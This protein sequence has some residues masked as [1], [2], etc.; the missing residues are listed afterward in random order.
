M[1]NS[2]S[3]SDLSPTAASRIE[4]SAFKR[5]YRAV[6]LV[7]ALMVMAVGVCVLF[8]W[9]TN[10]MQFVLLGIGGAVMVF[11][12]AFCFVLTAL[13]LIALAYDRFTIMRSLGAFLSVIAAIT[14]IQ[15][16]VGQDLG[17]DYLLF[18]SHYSVEPYTGLRMSINSAICFLL[19][20][21]AFIAMRLPDRKRWRFFAA[22]LLASA[23]LSISA[24][25]VVGFETGLTAA[26]GWRG[27]YGMSMPTAFCTIV[28]ATTL[29]A[30][31]A[32]YQSHMDGSLAKW[33][34]LIVGNAAIV[35]SFGL[36]HALQFQDQVRIQGKVL[37]QFDDLHGDLTYRLEHHTGVLMRMAKRWDSGGGIV[38]ANWRDDAENYLQALEGFEALAWVDS[39]LD[40]K[41]IES[42][43]PTNL[44]KVVA[45]DGKLRDTILR[46]RRRH[47][48]TAV[49]LLTGTAREPKVWLCEPTLKGT[50]DDGCLL[51]VFDLRRL[52]F[53]VLRRMPL[54]GQ[55]LE[56]RNQHIV[57]YESDPIAGIETS[58]FAQT[59]ELPFANLTW[60]LADAPVESLG[61]QPA[62]SATDGGLWGRTIILASAHRLLADGRLG[63]SKSA[64]RQY[65][66]STLSGHFR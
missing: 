32:R 43:E 9:V 8:G 22:A 44:A 45:S 62:E 25:A 13:S 36:W 60:T 30:W 4:S 61:G 39:N 53:Q 66:G 10:R 38:E 41:W 51:A 21:L 33:L 64:T 35:A 49:V 20:G 50:K 55:H 48:A 54:P 15:F 17:I 63:T 12:T 11:N 65:L 52:M 3:L 23:A 26:I 40:A 59:A 27:T 7:S 37:A 58:K 34:P 42:V 6:T 16:L 31:A 56:I 28:S 57:L 18:D 46:A 1:A 29:M 47:I 2:I 5:T 24:L 14:V 19:I